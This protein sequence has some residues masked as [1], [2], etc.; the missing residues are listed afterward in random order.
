MFGSW[1]V[2]I[3]NQR[4]PHRLSQRPSQRPRVS[5]RPPPARVLAVGTPHRSLALVMMNVMM[6]VMLNV[7]MNV[8]A[9]FCITYEQLL[10]ICILIYAYI[11]IYIYTYVFMVIYAYIFITIL[12]LY[13][14]KYI[15]IYIYLCEYFNIHIERYKY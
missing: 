1:P 2:P 3:T 9:D 7:M 15:Y 13:I 5:Q 14:Y 12:F 6:D 10:Y 8:M 11:C 4:P